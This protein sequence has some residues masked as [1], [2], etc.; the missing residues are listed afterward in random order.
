M[1]HRPAIITRA[2][3]VTGK[4]ALARGKIMREGAYFSVAVDHKLGFRH[5]VR[6]SG[7]QTGGQMAVSYLD[8]QVWQ[9]FD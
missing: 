1:I 4:S 9:E 5:F 2:S 6:K 7:F 3:V 8:P